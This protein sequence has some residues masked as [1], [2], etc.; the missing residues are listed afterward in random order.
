[1]NV[2]NLKQSFNVPADLYHFKLTFRPSF[3]A[4]HSTMVS[5]VIAS[6]PLHPYIGMPIK[7]L[8]FREGT[9]CGCLGRQ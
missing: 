6:S 2:L 5:A 7:S 3:L 8:F 9:L 1:M 4:I